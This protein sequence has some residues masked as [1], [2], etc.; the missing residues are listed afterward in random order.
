MKLQKILTFN[1][2]NL[3]ITFLSM[4]TVEFLCIV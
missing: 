2:K 4:L 1:V 3:K